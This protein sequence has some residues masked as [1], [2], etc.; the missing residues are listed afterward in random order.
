MPT[1]LVVREARPDEHEAVGRLTV[2]VYEAGGWA[3]PEYVPTLQDAAGRAAAA[4]VLVAVEDDGSADERLV[5][6]VAVAT[7]GGE[8]A[9]Q[10]GPGDAVVRMLV[11]DPAVRGRGIGEALMRACLDRAR[12]D[13]CVRVR[14][15]SQPDMVAAHRLY[16]RL[17]FV[18]VPELDWRPLPEVELLAY[19]LE[20]P[21]LQRFVDAQDADGTYDAAL[22]ELR[23]G[24]K[25]T[26]WMWFVFPQLAGLG[27]SPT[28]RHFAL[29]GPAE[30]RA[31]LAH[32]VLGDRL[33]ACAAALTAL[34]TADPVAVLGPV[35]AQKLSSS[36]TLFARVAP[37]EPVFGQVLEQF[38]GGQEDPA[39]VRLLDPS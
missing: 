34:A 20:L 38:F 17:G 23:A 3:N 39:T 19:V 21:D 14:L 1:P 31:Y 11:A 4:T 16:A 12:A 35:D 32:P 8:Y 27:R 13:G 33:R 15:S 22:R 18:R 29:S 24:R 36:M 28:A 26:H 30:A 25:Q 37:D 2:Q 5:G 10:A 9:E 6:A 7:R